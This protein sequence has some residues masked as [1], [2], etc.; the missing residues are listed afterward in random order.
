MATRREQELAVAVAVS[1]T[2]IGEIQV[3]IV[4]VKKDM[5]IVKEKVQNL[6]VKIA[7]GGILA[8]II[9]RY[10]PQI[11]EVAQAAFK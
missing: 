1:Q 4:E 10:A 11:I 9:V 6:E 2:Q 5:S 8:G 7:V 3:D